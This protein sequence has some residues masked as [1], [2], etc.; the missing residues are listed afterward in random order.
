MILETLWTSAPSLVAL[1]FPAPL[2]TFLLLNER[3][4]EHFFQ[5]GFRKFRVTLRRL[6]VKLIPGKTVFPE[7][8]SSVFSSCCGVVIDHDVRCGVSPVPL[9]R[10]ELPA[11]TCRT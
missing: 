5:T 6:Y 1:K 4:A 9:S 3:V 11:G 10:L 7:A 2:S 8:H